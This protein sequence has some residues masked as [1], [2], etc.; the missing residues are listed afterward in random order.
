MHANNTK[1]T[2]I[3]IGMSY[4]HTLHLVVWVP[5]TWDSFWTFPLPYHQPFEEQHLAAQRNNGD[6]P[7][8]IEEE[9]LLRVHSK[10][11]FGICCK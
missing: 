3:H 5:G 9:Q 8:Q 1:S 2:H 7:N 6:W 11:E 10:F 4:G